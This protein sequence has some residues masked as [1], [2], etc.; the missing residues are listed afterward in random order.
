MGK[1]PGGQSSL[2]II[3]LPVLVRPSLDTD[4]GQMVPE[5]FRKSLVPDFVISNCPRW[6][7][8]VPV[9]LVEHASHPLSKRAP[10]A[11][12]CLSCPLVGLVRLVGVCLASRF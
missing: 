8:F 10:S 3:Q 12:K 4:G 9:L 1:I 5:E 7:I 6:H 11:L 2:V